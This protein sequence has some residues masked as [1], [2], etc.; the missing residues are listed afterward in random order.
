MCTGGDVF[1]LSFPYSSEGEPVL[2]LEPIAKMLDLEPGDFVDRDGLQTFAPAGFT[3]ADVFFV[4]AGTTHPYG[5]VELFSR[6]FPDL[7]DA[8]VSSTLR[9]ENV[10]IT[11]D[12]LTRLRAAIQGRLDTE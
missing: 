4:I 8:L 7:A 2:D 5:G 6:I 12:D 10:I 11:E 1:I 9:W 3:I